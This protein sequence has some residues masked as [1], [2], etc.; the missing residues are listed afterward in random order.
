MYSQV[1]AL[2]LLCH[3][4]GPRLMRHGTHPATNARPPFHRGHLRAR[5]S[6]NLPH[7]NAKDEEDGS[8]TAIWDR[9]AK[10]IAFHVPYNHQ[11]GHKQH[12]LHQTCNMSLPLAKHESNRL[13]GLVYRLNMQ[14]KHQSED[15]NPCKIIAEKT[16]FLP[17]LRHRKDSKGS[18]CKCWQHTIL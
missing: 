17:N 5:H 1:V 2:F 7:K 9:N 3:F 15:Q 10:K 8:N 12:N 14:T 6:L 4:D 13:W 18:V 11:H 16:K